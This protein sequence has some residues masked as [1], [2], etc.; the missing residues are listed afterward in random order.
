MRL[1]AIRIVRVLSNSRRAGWSPRLASGWLPG[2]TARGQAVA[3]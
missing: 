2:E 3:G 1:S